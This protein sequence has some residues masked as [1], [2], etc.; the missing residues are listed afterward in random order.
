MLTYLNMKKK[1]DIIY[2]GNLK[3]TN[4]FSLPV[5]LSLASKLKL[6]WTTIEICENFVVAVLYG[7]TFS[8]ANVF[9]S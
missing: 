3:V 7:K 8:E 9:Y 5:I 4:I 6:C 1:T 2:F